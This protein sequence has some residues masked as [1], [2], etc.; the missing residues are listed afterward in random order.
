MSKKKEKSKKLFSEEKKEKIQQKNIFMGKME[1]GEGE[2]GGIL[3][4]ENSLEVH[5]S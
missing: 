3:R 4:N 1:E 5:R 2:K